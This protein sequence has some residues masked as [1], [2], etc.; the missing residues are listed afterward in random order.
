M[1]KLLAQVFDIS[2]PDQF[3][4]LEN[5]DFGS[6]ITIM[7]SFVLIVAALAFFFIFVIG[8]IKWIT[9][10]GDK[11]KVEGARSQI[12]AGFIGLV[13]VFAAWAILDIIENFFDVN[14]RS[15]NLDLI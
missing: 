7:V 12:T 1:K 9:S 4:N 10:G 11:G 3:S 14:L 5:I 6:L 13:I 15:F 8:G 2:A